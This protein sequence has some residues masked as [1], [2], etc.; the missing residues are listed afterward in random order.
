MLKRTAEPIVRLREMS[1]LLTRYWFE[2]E[3]G[4]GVGV[5]AYSLDDAKGLIAQEP[6]IGNVNLNS[7]VENIDVQTL[8]ENHVIP[9]MGPVNFRGIWYPNFFK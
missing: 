2:S 6:S 3:A 7:V 8:D 1:N 9:N 5:T 4:Y